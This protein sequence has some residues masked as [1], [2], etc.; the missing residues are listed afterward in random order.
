MSKPPK[1]VERIR[2]T[3]AL[4]QFP[5]AVLA[6]VEHDVYVLEAEAAAA[7]AEAQAT[8]ARLEAEW[9]EWR[10]A[11]GYAEEQLRR[12]GSDGYASGLLALLDRAALSPREGGT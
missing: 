7:L 11:G 1:T 10:K 4:G 6:S 2:S 3:G 12:L 5:G 9:A 8:I